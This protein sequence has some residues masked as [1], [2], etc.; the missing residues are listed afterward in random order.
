MGFSSE[1]GFSVLPD[2]LSGMLTF[3]FFYL[4]LGFC[5]TRSSKRNAHFWVFDLRLGFCPDVFF[6][7]SCKRNTNSWVFPPLGIYNFK[8]VNPKTQIAPHRPSAIPT[9]L[10][11]IVLGPRRLMGT[12][13][14]PD[15]DDSA[16]IVSST[17]GGFCVAWVGLQG[18]PKNHIKINEKALESQ[19]NK[20]A[21]RCRSNFHHG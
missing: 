2:A 4:R 3:C 18:P 12:L 8:S 1:L 6:A 17:K 19:I 16:K 7:R 5:F 13:T 9:P 15:C 14:A 11:N 21:S 20:V 10:K